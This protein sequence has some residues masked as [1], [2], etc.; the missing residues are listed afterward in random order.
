MPWTS[1]FFT[2]KTCF[3][4]VDNTISE[5][6]YSIF[7]FFGLGCCTS[8]SLAYDPVL[9][10]AD[11]LCPE[12]LLLAFPKALVP[13]PWTWIAL[14]IYLNLTLLQSVL[15]TKRGIS[16]WETTFIGSLPMCQ[17]PFVL[18]VL[19]ALSYLNLITSL[20]W[21]NGCHDPTYNG[22]GRHGEIK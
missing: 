17:V 4:L 2:F 12:W 15:G 18:T 14:S 3:Y 20:R 19:P 5:M 8:Q 22:A 6:T 16:N 9:A 1:F 11:S 21:D 10:T 13:I 7:F